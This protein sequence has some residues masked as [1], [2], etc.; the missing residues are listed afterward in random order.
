MWDTWA[1]HALT[2]LCIQ[3]DVIERAVVMLLRSNMLN[4]YL[5]F[6]KQNKRSNATEYTMPRAYRIRTN[7]QTS[8]EE[9]Q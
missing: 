8:L 4:K 3:M 7:N 5:F 2:Q 9:K 1:W 6:N